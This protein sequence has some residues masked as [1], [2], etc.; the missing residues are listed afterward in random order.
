[1]QDP[2]SP[3]FKW[4]QNGLRHSYASYR[5]AVMEDVSKLSLEL[6]NSP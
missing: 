3:P 5:L 2:E 6:G 4:K 1:V